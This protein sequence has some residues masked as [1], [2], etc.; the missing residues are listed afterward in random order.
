MLFHQ[1]TIP[2][3]A[4]QSVL[5]RPSFPGLAV[6]LSLLSLFQHFIRK[7]RSIHFTCPITMST[8][9]SFLLLFLLQMIG[10]ARSQQVEWLTSNPVD[11]NINP[12][13]PLHLVCAS[14]ADHIYVARSTTL[15]YLYGTVY[16]NSVVEQRDATGATTWSFTLGDSVLV[17]AMASD[18]DGRVIL[19][20]RFFNR[21]QLNG[22]QEL[23]ALFSDIFPETFLMALDID[24][25]LLWQRNIS[26]NDPQG[27]E[28]Q[29][30]T[31]DPQGRAWYAT[32]NFFRADINRL[33]DL[34][35]DIETR[36][37]LDAKTIGS[38]SF[39]P[40]GGLYVSGGAGEPGITLN[41]TF[42]PITSGYSMFV[43]RMGVDGAAQ[44][45][46]TAVD[47]TFQR[48]R[49]QA[50]DFGHAYLVGA[51]FDSLSW[52]DLYF[53][54]PEWNSTFFVTRLDSTGHFEWGYQPPQGE[55]FSGQFT[56][57]RDQVLGVDE[58]GNATILG[59]TNGMVD[60]GNNVVTN[61]GGI[62]ERAVTLLQLDTA[63]TPH[64]QL[65]GSSPD[66]D[67]PQSLSVLPNGICHLAVQV[68]DTF[69]LGGF[70][71]EL[72]SPHVV[73][74]RVAP[75]T[76][77]IAESTLGSLAIYP[78]PFSST[79]TISNPMGSKARVSIFDASGR[80]VA[81]ENRTDHLG[82]TLPPGSYVIEMVQD[83]NRSIGRV[84]K[85]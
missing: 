83:G 59:V 65:Q 76:T 23:S 19:G 85:E 11:F 45:L 13:M 69:Q 73:V 81:R 42:Y 41:G 15:S 60:W 75:V 49:V 64:W 16:G 67:V 37:I 55:P 10:S 78:S 36:P 29:A 71:A 79:F 7:Q 6:L 62:T 35:N 33:D 46:H 47:I 66:Y 4:Q 48:P 63:G 82:N 74:A 1:Y 53:N 2:P 54:G 31:F 5:P 8:K 34:G 38:I 77:G 68:R 58:V 25:N 72:S 44:W 43:A 26:P 24:G 56:L 22:E 80:I 84:V 32:C 39:D 21:V 40:Q 17:Q 9:L 27:T 57:G 51:P 14:D 20:G 12:D 18:G 61:A 52:G 50:D 28:L 30:I 70:T 3:V